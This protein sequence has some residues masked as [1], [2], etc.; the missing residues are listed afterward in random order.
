MYIIIN[1]FFV[2]LF[3]GSA[4]KEKV[5][6]YIQEKGEVKVRS[7][8][9]FLIGP[10]RVGKT[11]T[12]RRLT[13]KI[14]LGS[15]DIISPS[16][17][18]DSPVTV[19]LYSDIDQS[20]VNI[21][22][23][24]WR[25]QGIGDQFR[26]LWNF[27]SKLVSSPSSSSSNGAN[28]G[29]SSVASQ[30]SES[31]ATAATTGSPQMS[32]QD[33]E[34]PTHRVQEYVFDNLEKFPSRAETDDWKTIGEFLE[35][36]D[37]LNIV[38]IGGQ[39]EFHEILPMLLHGPALNLI[40]FNVTHDLDSP[41]TVVYCDIDGPTQMQYKSEFTIKAIIQ[42]A[43]CSISSLET[44]VA[45]LIGTHLDKSND[46][47]VRKLDDSIQQ[48]Y[49]D[50]DFMRKDVLW[51]VDKVGEEEKYIHSLNNVGG[52][53]NDIE[54]LRRLI[55]QIVKVR[56]EQE[57][58]PTTY[59]LLH[60][61]LRFKFESRGWC[62]YEQC[63]E[64]AESC[65]ISKEDLPDVLEYLHD[66][67]GTILYY[68]SLEKLSKRVILNVNL[69]MKPPSELFATAFGAMKGLP[70]T[71][72]TIR[73]TGEIPEYLMKKA[74]S[75]S[76]SESC[77]PTDE[78]VELLES[79]Y[80]LYK[81]VQTSRKENVYFLPCLLLP[82]HNII[83]ES[84]NPKFLSGLTYSPLLVIPSTG[85]IPLG[86]FQ[87]S[88]VKFSQEKKWKLDKL[89][90]FRNRIRF[91][92]NNR[93]LHVEIRSLPGCLEVHIVNIATCK[94]DLIPEFRFELLKVLDEV[95]S[96][97]PHTKNVHWDLGFYC[98]YGLEFGKCHPARCEV[99]SANQEVFCNELDVVACETIGCRETS[100]E[101]VN[102]QKCWFMVRAVMKL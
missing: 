98:P 62:F 100:V 56:F 65:G 32:H 77:I 26:D 82:D 2:D 40:F 22:K 50:S 10:S 101:L 6:K 92:F 48:L 33:Q 28:S 18:I 36:L 75:T 12:C 71:A 66:N 63:E 31:Q 81:N 34:T 21:G 43:L 41:Y 30:P 72:K 53:S 52:K 60:L 54:E 97:S 42:R 68:R 95:T 39:P 64:I 29:D 96:L 49:K 61:F 27:L 35:N 80:I 99:D 23:K 91:Y 47:A 3:V 51:Q 74:C 24:G 16:T 38:D 102:K 85:F 15:S 78:I 37:L 11:T 58:V 90:R 73:Q 9:L 88:V 20:L 1:Y 46:E 13:H 93:S 86:F 76:S 4:K 69:I 57:S 89:H 14:V 94:Q 87:A 84:D 59:L 45:L 8:K 17:G 5:K 25:S 83:K 70:N 67:F 7:L 55:T 19:P 79:R 44:S